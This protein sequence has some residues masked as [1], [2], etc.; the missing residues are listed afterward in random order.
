[1]KCAS[2]ADRYVAGAAGAR[3][4]RVAAHAVR[5]RSRA[6]PR[7]PP[8]RRGSLAG[9]GDSTVVPSGAAAHRADRQGARWRTDIARVFA[10]REKEQRVSAANLA[11]GARLDRLPLRRRRRPRRGCTTTRRRRR[12]PTLEGLAARVGVRLAARDGAPA[13]SRSARRAS[14][15][16]CE[17]WPRIPGWRFR[18]IP[19]HSRAIPDPRA[20]LVP[21]GVLASATGQVLGVICGGAV[22]NGP[23]L[24]YEVGAGPVVSCGRSPPPKPAR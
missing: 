13:A 15:S 1:L 2:R 6:R 14:S 21:Q 22:G 10:Q 24:V 5:P 7:R 20:S 18:E 9:G 17:L 4:L 12:F 19:E 8:G 11:E 23:L 16:G 3:R